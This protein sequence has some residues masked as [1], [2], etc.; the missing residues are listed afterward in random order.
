MAVENPPFTVRRGDDRLIWI[1]VVDD[2]GNPVDLSRV[3]AV[4]L[5]YGRDK[6][7]PPAKTVTQDDL[8]LRGNRA[9]YRMKYTETSELVAQRTYWLQCRVTIPDGTPDGFRD[10]VATGSFVVQTSQQ[11]VSGT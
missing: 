1:D 9:I 8:T 6:A 11:A 7:G 5:T 2:D 10:T 3:T 4:V